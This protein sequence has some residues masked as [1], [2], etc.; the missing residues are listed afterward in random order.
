V[1]ESQRPLNPELGLLL[2]IEAARTARTNEAF[3]ALRLAL[4]ELYERLTIPEYQ[5]TA[6][7]AFRAHDLIRLFRVFRGFH[8]VRW[9]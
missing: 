9:G 5:G 7:A 3:E 8:G 2:A 1:A 6:Y 4:P